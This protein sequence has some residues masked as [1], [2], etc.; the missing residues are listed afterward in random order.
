MAVLRPGGSRMRQFLFVLLVAG[1]VWWGYSRFTTGSEQVHA[2]VRTDGLDALVQ[3]EDERPAATAGLPEPVATP[4]PLEAGQNGDEQGPLDKLAEGVR[5]GEAAAF[6][7]A[8]RVLAFP[9]APASSRQRVARMVLELEV[10][11]A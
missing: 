6:D 1:L 7:Q 9:S 11:D 3:K 2:A 4:Q 8:W 10:K 5:A